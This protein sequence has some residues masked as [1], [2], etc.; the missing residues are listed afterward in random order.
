MWVARGIAAVVVGIGLAGVPGTASADD[1]WRNQAPVF[2]APSRSFLDVE[3]VG[4]AEAWAVGYQGL[5]TVQVGPWDPPLPPILLW[6]RAPRPVLQ[7]WTGRGWK[8]H[9]PEGI[10]EEGTL[11]E[12]EVSH[13][14]VWALGTIIDGTGPLSGRRHYAYIGRW[15]GTQ[16]VQLD[17]PTSTSAE[18]G[19]R[20]LSADSGGLWMTERGMA[21]RFVDGPGWTGYDL[22][23][24]I[25]AIESY[26]SG[27]AWA[28]GVDAARDTWVRHWDGAAWTP[29]AL[30]AG[31]GGHT[32]H[33]TGP[34]TGWT[35]TDTGLALWDGAAWTTVPY[36]AGYGR[37]LVYPAWQSTPYA[38]AD[39]DG[40][41]ILAKYVQGS[42]TTL[43]HWTGSA[44]TT[45]QAD[46]VPVAE[47]G[48]G[49]FWLPQQI[50]QHDG[51]MGLFSLTG[52]ALTQVAPPVAVDHRW[53][54]DPLPGTDHVLVTGEDFD[55]NLRAF[56][57]APR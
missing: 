33:P 19:L 31:T 10:P 5:L 28:S 4:P 18:G 3:A 43:L 50:D 22:G 35:A 48:R 45:V 44:W 11:N 1:V 37:D 42:P 53:D 25:G 24:H 12:I 7:Q 2:T 30:P 32:F 13:G 6:Q 21:Y 51:S 46:G 15:T 36:P 17:G 14:Q 39:V 49:G 27:E 54:V 57:N 8:S 9:Q 26:D 40:P 23:S 34:A 47:D 55:G 41:W 52:G 20:H 16:F 56:T 38:T 29:L